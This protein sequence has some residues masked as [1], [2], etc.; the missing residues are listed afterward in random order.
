M[1]V[2]I[3]NRG[4][5]ILAIDPTQTFL[6]D[7][8]G[9]AWPLLSEE[10]AYRRIKGHVELGEMAK[11]SGKPALVAGA[12][13]ALI[14]FAVGIVSGHDVGKNLARGAA[15]GATAGA[16]AGG[17][18]GGAEVGDRIRSDLRDRSLKN[19][20]IEPG[21][22]AHGFLFF[23]GKHEAPDGVSLRLALLVDGK[24]RVVNIPLGRR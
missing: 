15:I 20:T 8:K 13:G 7:S 1:Q 4:P 23:P 10:E 22:L 19:R 5:H 3:E 9:R 24:R 14:G 11:R 17:A 18:S 16:L 2:V 12:A 6:I 21:S